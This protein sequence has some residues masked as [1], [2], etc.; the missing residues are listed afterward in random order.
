M[1][2]QRSK[3]RVRTLRTGKGLSLTLRADLAD[4]AT[5]QISVLAQR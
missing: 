2:F 4:I 1:D 5:G 3:L